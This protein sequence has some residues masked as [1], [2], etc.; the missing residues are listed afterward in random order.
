RISAKS[1]LLRYAAMARGYAVR[2]RG[3][4]VGAQEHGGASVSRPPKPHLKCLVDGCDVISYCRG[5]CKKHY[6]RMWRCGDANAGE[7]STRFMACVA[8]TD[9]CWLWRGPLFK[10]GYGRLS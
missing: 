7:V 9:G 4:S 1:L 6:N 8:K 10:S 5:W 2:R 3:R